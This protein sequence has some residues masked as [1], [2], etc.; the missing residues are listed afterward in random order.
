MWQKILIYHVGVEGG[1]TAHQSHDGQDALRLV[2]RVGSLIAKRGGPRASIAA[3]SKGA[4]Q[5]QTRKAITSCRLD[6]YP[7]KWLTGWAYEVRASTRLPTYL[8]RNI[9]IERTTN[10]SLVGQSLSTVQM[11]IAYRSQHQMLCVQ[12]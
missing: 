3:K 11:T 1:A 5:E 2:A 7:S 10:T 9:L 8:V 6:G 12:H 4:S